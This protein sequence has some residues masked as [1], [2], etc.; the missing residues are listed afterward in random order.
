MHRYDIRRWAF[1]L[2]D[3]P[4]AWAKGFDDSGW[5]RLTVP[6]DWSVE[7]PF[8]EHHSSGTGYLPGGIGWYRPISRWPSWANSP[9]ATRGS[10][11]RAS[12]RTRRSG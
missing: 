1:F 2:G 7:Q 4:Q 3:E 12:T 9:A 5:R 10:A 8:A 11:S 6:H